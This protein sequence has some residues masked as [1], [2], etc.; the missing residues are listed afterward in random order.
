MFHMGAGFNL[1]SKQYCL[2]CL[3][4]TVLRVATVWTLVSVPDGSRGRGQPP[5]DVTSPAGPSAP[6]ECETTGIKAG[7][8]CQADGTGGQSQTPGLCPAGS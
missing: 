8:P 5:H 3:Y 7:R 1:A 6:T 2:G 4:V